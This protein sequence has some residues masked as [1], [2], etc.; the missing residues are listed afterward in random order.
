MIVN[1]FKEKREMLI[2]YEV[3]IL[4]E[5][6]MHIVFVRANSWEVKNEVLVFYQ[7]KDGMRSQALF[8]VW[9]YVRRVEEEAMIRPVMITTEFVKNQ[10]EH[11]KKPR[12]RLLARN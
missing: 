10:I 6:Q 8:K 2:A 3:G 7:D 5:N 11:V 12:Q 4:N 9:S 1:L